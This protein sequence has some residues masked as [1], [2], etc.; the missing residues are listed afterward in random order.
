[1]RWI[2]LG[3][4]LLA[5]PAHP[6]WRTVG[7]WEIHQTSQG[8]IAQTIE[9]RGPIPSTLSLYHPVLGRDA[10]EMRNDGWSISEGQEKSIYVVVGDLAFETKAIS[11]SD[12]AILFPA[13]EK[14][15]EAIS[16]SGEITAFLKIDEER[17]KALEQF[18]LSGSAAA[19]AA[20]GAC[21]ADLRKTTGAAEK[22]EKLV[23]ADPFAAGR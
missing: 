2:V 4:A 7:N 5:A 11:P 15:L 22:R 9:R 17:E 6:S 14:L 19:L 8:C 3:L 20:S 10:V 21:L 23:P 16:A 12:H 1:M 18:D 13:N